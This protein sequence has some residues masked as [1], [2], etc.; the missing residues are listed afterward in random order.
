MILAGEQRSTWR[1]TCPSAT[2]STNN[3]TW[4]TLGLNPS[5]VAEKP[6]TNCLRCGMAVSESIKTHSVDMADSLY[7]QPGCLTLPD[8]NFLRAAA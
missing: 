4:S 7:G 6:G 2:T 1:K 8:M 3:L 5:S